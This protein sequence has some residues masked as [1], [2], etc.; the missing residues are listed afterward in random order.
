MAIL[1]LAESAHISDCAGTARPRAA[2]AMD[3]SSEA[4]SAISWPPQPATEVSMII[5]TNLVVRSMVSTAR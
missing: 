2:S 4:S 1:G 3:V 5:D